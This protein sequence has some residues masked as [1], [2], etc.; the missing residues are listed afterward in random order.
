MEQH[1]LARLDA[2]RL[3]LAEHATIDCK[4]II[5]SLIALLAASLYRIEHRRFLR[6]FEFRNGRGRRQEIERHLGARQ[7][8]PEFFQGQKY[9]TIVGTRLPPWL[10]V[11]EPYLAAVKT[12]RQ[13]GVGCQMGVIE[14]EPRWT[15]RKTDAPHAMRRNEGCPLFR[16]PVHI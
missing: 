7:I 2:D 11:D 6:R 8:R 16:S 9:L 14:P 5:G 13:V 4:E 12:E 1:A 10:N 3:A 15:W